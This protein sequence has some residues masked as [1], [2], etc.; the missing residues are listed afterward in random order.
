MRRECSRL[1]ALLNLRCVLFVAPAVALSAIYGQSYHGGFASYY[2]GFS[3]DGWF[4]FLIGMG[5]AG[6]VVSVPYWLPMMPAV[7]LAFFGVRESLRRVP[8]ARGYCHHCGY[9]LRAT[10]GRCPE[11]G[12]EPAAA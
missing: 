7:L 9:D 1:Y 4:T 8:P 11:C 10:P 12:R 3:R 5:H 6:I 2:L